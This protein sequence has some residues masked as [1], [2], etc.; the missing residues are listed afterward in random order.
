[1]K[2]VDLM[3]YQPSPRHNN[4]QHLEHAHSLQPVS[5]KR[6]RIIDDIQE[7]SKLEDAVGQQTEQEQPKAPKSHEYVAEKELYFVKETYWRSVMNVK[8]KLKNMELWIT[9]YNNEPKKKAQILQL[10]FMSDLF[11]DCDQFGKE[12]QCSQ[13]PLKRT[14]KYSTI[15]H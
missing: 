9:D 12:I 13:Q 10:K 5:K 3:D 7:D 8:V 14:V 15:S 4:L 2:F 11:Y 6:V 1:M